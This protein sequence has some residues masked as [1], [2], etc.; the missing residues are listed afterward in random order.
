MNTATKKTINIELSPE[1]YIKL[2]TLSNEKV[3]GSM[4]SFCTSA[5]TD[6]II[7]F[8]KARKI[9]MMQE[10]THDPEYLDRCKEIQQDYKY[11]DYPGGREEW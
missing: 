10:A 8:E 11:I 5:I 4:R 9:K 2:K 3:I 1:I 7:E 6:K